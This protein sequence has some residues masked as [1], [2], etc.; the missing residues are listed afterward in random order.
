LCFPLNGV[1]INY[2]WCLSLLT[3]YVYMRFIVW[4]RP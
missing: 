4:C 3:Q 1:C 2:W